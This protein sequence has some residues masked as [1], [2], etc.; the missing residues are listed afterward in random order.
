MDTETASGQDGSPEQ[1]VPL[2]ALFVLSATGGLIVGIAAMVARG[3][4]PGSV[5]WIGDSGA[6]WAVAAFVAGAAAAGARP[7]ACA[8]AGLLAHWGAVLG[9]HG[10]TPLLWL[11]GQDLRAL[12]VWTACGAVAG[13]LLGLAGH[14]WR[15]RRGRWR[16]GAAALLGAVLAA[17]GAFELIG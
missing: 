2:W 16:T 4:L 1:A 15:A 17:G 3:P 7:W 8:V 13:P 11:D 5:A 14:V 10:F 6:A 9:Y 12:L